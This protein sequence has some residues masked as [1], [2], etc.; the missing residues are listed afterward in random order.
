MPKYFYFPILK[1]RS[2]EFSA[3]E[4]LE[5][6]IKDE[7]LPIVEMTGALGYTYPKN[8]KI[9]SLRGTH[10]E[11]DINTKII[12][13]LGLVGNRKFILDI[14]DDNSLKYDGL[15]DRNGGL[16][17]HTN[18]Y[19]TWIDF[20]TK[21]SNFQ[22]QVIPTIQFNTDYR[23]DVDSQ[24]RSLNASFDHIAIKLPVFLA[25]EKLF[26]SSIVFNKNIQRIIDYVLSLLSKNK[27]KLIVILDFGYNK[28]FPSY[29]SAV[30]N[31]LQSS[32]K[33]ISKLKA[34]IPVSSSFPNFVSDVDKPIPSEEIDIYNC[35]KNQFAQANNIFCGDYASIHPTKYEMGGGGWI[36]RIDYIVRDKTGRPIEYDYV[37]G[38]Q[39]NTSSEYINLARDVISSNNYKRV[40]ELTIQ[41]DNMIAEKARNG[42]VGKA[43]AYWIAVR[44][45][46]YMTIQYL[47]L[48]KQDSF[49]FL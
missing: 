20:L 40:S 48:K 28:N 10:R 26:D 15:S 7:I 5:D 18:G 25:G 21:D 44:S 13:I 41:G 11:G 1:T 23:N 32:L 19:N 16:L 43:P 8:Y 38:S 47:Y 39:K 29:Q 22:K 37:R 12:K 49:L 46:T 42:I 2:A 6:Y 31:G 34:L 33:D 35:V 3:Y 9:E 30:T 14:T 24:I 45:S 17:D 27:L 36:P 4:A